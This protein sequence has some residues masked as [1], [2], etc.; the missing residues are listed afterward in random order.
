MIQL[1]FKLPVFLPDLY[2]PP[3]PVPAVLH[4]DVVD[5]LIQ[6]HKDIGKGGAA[7][8]TLT[9]PGP[10]GKI[11][12]PLFVIH[13]LIAGEIHGKRVIALIIVLKILHHPGLL[14]K[15]RRLLPL[16]PARRWKIPQS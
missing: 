6:I 13:H 1:G 8:F 4:P 7:D 9:H 16:I 3:Q 2:Q 12:P 11:G 10:P 5:Q 15:N 14:V